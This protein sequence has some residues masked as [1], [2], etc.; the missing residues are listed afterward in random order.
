[1]KKLYTITI[2]FILLSMIIGAQDLTGEKPPYIFGDEIKINDDT[3]INIS[4]GAPQVAVFENKVYLI[5]FDN[6]DN[7][8]GNSD[9]Y[10]AKS[11]DTGGNFSENKKIGDQ[12]GSLDDIEVGPTGNIYGIFAYYGNISFM[13]ST[14]EGDTFSDPINVNDEESD[15]GCSFPA[16]AVDN[17]DNIYVVWQD[18]RN[19]LPSKE[20]SNPDIYL[21]KSNDGGESF[22]PNIRV[23]DG[24]SLAS[25]WNPDIAV[26]E[27]GGV[28]VVWQD[29]RNDQ[30]GGDA[31]WDIYFAKS[32][33][34]GKSF[35]DNVMVSHDETHSSQ[36]NPRIA[37]DSSGNIYV[38]WAD[39]RPGQGDESGNYKIY[40]SKSKNSGLSFE[41]DVFIKGGPVGAR[42]MADDK[43][44]YIF[45]VFGIGY[46]INSEDCG[47][48][49]S[50]PMYVTPE[51]NTPRMALDNQSN[52]YLVW[53]DS[54]ESS[55][56]YGDIY[57][58][59]G[60]R[61]KPSNENGDDIQNNNQNQDNIDTWLWVIVAVILIALVAYIAKRRRSG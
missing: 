10:F 32:N 28:Y 46:M 37:T 50:E 49:F 51:D 54:R 44:I 30:S 13:K 33:D 9:A 42:I 35:D 45:Y 40:F 4:Q 56:W 5:W 61:T 60:I 24:I 25:Q 29:A 52:I 47:K 11:T 59:K 2:L 36:S 48:T 34:G 26:S 1:M 12:T 20:S 3:D 16:M 39:Q 15:G 31:D 8:N 27:D 57:F 21:A 43:G 41:S 17:D 38:V 55:G 6:R 22:G 19:H 14:N 18:Y 7:T 58:K 23:N 53:T